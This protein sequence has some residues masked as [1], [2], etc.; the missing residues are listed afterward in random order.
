LVSGAT[1]R[2]QLGAQLVDQ[3]L[4]IFWADPTLLGA[5]AS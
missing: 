2:P 3:I 1:R 5:L 4:G